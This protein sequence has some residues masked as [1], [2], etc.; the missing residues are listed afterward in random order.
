VYQ[1][2]TL[3]EG[4]AYYL[5]ILLKYRWL[6]ISITATATI[7]AIAFCFASIRLPPEK[8]PLPNQYTASATILVQRGTEND[9]SSS[10]RSA[11][12]IANNPTDRSSEFDNGALLLMVLQSR[13]VLDKIAEEFEIPK[14][15]HIPD[16]SKSQSRRKLLANLRFEN[17]RAAAAITISYKDIDPVFAKNL[18]NGLVSLLS[19]WYSQ[20]MGSSK[21]K[22]KQLLEAKINEVKADVDSLESRQ[23][24]LQ[25]KYGA[26]TAQDLGASQASALA[27]LRSQLILKEIDI[28]NYASIAT[29]DDPKLLQ[30]QGERQYIA[31]LINRTQ[32]GMP[33]IL[34]NKD[35]AENLPDVQTEFNNLSIELDVQRKIYNTLSHQ[36]EVLK[37]TSDSE[38]PF[39]IMELAEV[40]DAKSGPQRIVLIEEVALIALLTSVVLSF[41]LNGISQIR[42]KAG[43]VM[44]ESERARL[45]WRLGEKTSSKII[46]KKD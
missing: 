34:G 45:P 27:A 7:G 43:S 1:E 44:I 21:L 20:N 3:L 31:D 10:I 37:L 30:L 8:S 26:L 4:L 38:P 15:Y 42:S 18:T 39:Q 24:E 36:Y 16:R 46:S 6:I 12:G 19:E 2:R 25:K 40:P 5:S 22:Q 41:L 33:E 9:L 28:R 23:N 35:G 29:A 32:K 14:K 11:L 17:N 13:T